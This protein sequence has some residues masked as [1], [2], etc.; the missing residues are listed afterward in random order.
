MASPHFGEM[1]A[2]H[3]LESCATRRRLPHRP[4]RHA[5]GAYKSAYT[6]RDWVIN[7]FNS[8]M[9]YDT[10]VKAQMAGD[11]MDAKSSRQR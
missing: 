8:D 4:E 9:S 7:S 2:R 10:F 6:Y 5:Q 1:W 3:W 11:Q